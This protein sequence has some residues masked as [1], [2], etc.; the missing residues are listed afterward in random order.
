MAAPAKKAAQA[1]RFVG[2]T[3]GEYQRYLRTAKEYVVNLRGDESLGLY[4][5]PCDWNTGHPN[6]FQA[7]YQVLNLLR[8]M[9]L[10]P[11]ARIAEM[12]SGAGWLT[13]LLLG[14]GYEVWAVEPS[15]AMLEVAR[16]RVASFMR[17]HHFAPPYKVRFFCES[18]EDCTIPD[19]SVDAVLF[20]ESLHHVIDEDRALS[21][22]HRI[23]RPGG[24]LGTSGESNWQP[25]NR[26]PEAFWQA[27][28]AQ[29]GTLESPFTYEYLHRK[30][31]E[32]G[33]ADVTRYHGI[34]LNVPVSQENATIKQ[35]ANYPAQALNNVT[36]RKPLG[37]PCSTDPGAVAQAVIRLLSAQPSPDGRQVR[38][39]IRLQNSGR[40]AWVPDAPQ[41]GYVTVALR[42]KA[43]RGTP[44]EA[45]PRARLR[46]LVLPGQEI[47]LEHVYA[48][49]S[50][51]GELAWSVDLVNEHRYWFSAHGTV[52]APWVLS[53][54]AA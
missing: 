25:G 9:A 43:G 33:F 22:C 52:A 3:T 28:M 14:L 35:L 37:V 30:L 46:R 7:I 39:R 17:H 13:E 49:P 44:V 41:G 26:E 45:V 54:P 6:F 32:H 24:V 40:V 34:N 11:G 53:G 31:V 20:H 16:E 1:T 42:G 27:E 36:A 15:A 38:L 5:K 23:L 21:E 19:D 51:A 29:F 8:S 47:E 48:L 2:K 12:G 4:Q 50:G 10:P 18:V